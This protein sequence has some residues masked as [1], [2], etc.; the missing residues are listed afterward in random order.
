VI[1][2]IR[3]RIDD[4][5]SGRVL[6]FFEGSSHLILHG[7]LG[8]TQALPRSSG[9]HAGLFQRL[10]GLFTSYSRPFIFSLLK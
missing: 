4:T 10:A 2:F 6:V 5:S 9:R 3:F 8:G 7:L 1:V